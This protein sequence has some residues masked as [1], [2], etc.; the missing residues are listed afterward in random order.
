MLTRLEACLWPWN[1]TESWVNLFEL[2]AFLH[3]IAAP[4]T[5]NV[6]GALRIVFRYYLI[7]SNVTNVSAGN[8]VIFPIMMH[9]SAIQCAAMATTYESTKGL[10][11]AIFEADNNKMLSVSIQQYASNISKMVY[12]KYLFI[13]IDWKY[14]CKKLFF[15]MKSCRSLKVSY[16]RDKFW[17]RQSPSY[18]VYL[19]LSPI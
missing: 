1:H 15:W 4:N 13:N 12:T 19:L 8:S 18:F 6:F 3:L 7:L 10:A 2:L 17:N 9:V 5:F 11:L 14:K 16:L